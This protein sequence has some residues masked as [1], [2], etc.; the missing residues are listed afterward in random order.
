M[1]YLFFLFMMIG[2]NP[3][4]AGLPVEAAKDQQKLLASA[5]KALAANKK[6][7]YDFTRIILAGR[8][9]DQ[10]ATF[11]SDGYVQHNPNVPT[12]LQGFLD[13]FSKLPGG[14]RPTPDTVDGLVSMQAE[15]DIVTMSFVNELQDATGASYTTTWFDMFRVTDG[16]ITEHWDCDVKPAK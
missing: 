13:Y 12:G 10:A 16:K 5:D 8:H 14:P 6:L 9:L 15:G 7:V 2:M 1:K 11:L 3:A 4:W